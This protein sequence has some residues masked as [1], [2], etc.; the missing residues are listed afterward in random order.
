MSE[1]QPQYSREDLEQ[2]GL[3]E[4]EINAYLNDADSDG[5]SDGDEEGDEDGEA[6]AV[7]AD[8]DAADDGSADDDAG[9]GEGSGESGAEE[10]AGRQPGAQQPQS[11]SDDGDNP[12]AAP[13]VVADT[14]RYRPR[15]VQ[16]LILEDGS[17]ATAEWMASRLE[18][19][20]DAMDDLDEKAMSGDMDP[21]DMRAARRKL[22]AER[23]LIADKVAETKAAAQRNS[24]MYQDACDGYLA[25][26]SGLLFAGNRRRMAALNDAIQEVAQSK[27][28]AGKSYS[29]LLAQAGKVA[30]ADLG[31]AEQK[32]DGAKPAAKM[33]A[34]GDNNGN[35]RTLASVPSATGNAA[36]RA[37]RF[38]YLDRLSGEAHMEALANLSDAQ[39]EA[40]YRGS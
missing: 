32:T 27:D 35:V 39:R 10:E 8:G 25:T 18:S 30:A 28:A 5:E 6:V 38:A 16:P 17:P 19:I 31:L 33:R 1:E 37:D 2:M 14:G 20:D 21:A 34:V 24:D 12:G 13:D 4:R 7:G 9:P 3:D 11:L 15:Y 22:R 40:Y 36:R 29:W 23:A 26:K